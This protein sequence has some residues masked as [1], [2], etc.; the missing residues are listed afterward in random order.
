MLNLNGSMNSIGKTP[1]LGV[2]RPEWRPNILLRQPNAVA[3]Q[4]QAQAQ[5]QA[6]A[7]AQAQAQSQAQA[8]AQAEAPT[9]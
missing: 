4:A 8:Q 1:F 7:Q 3:A 6:Q 2:V 9:Q 5:T